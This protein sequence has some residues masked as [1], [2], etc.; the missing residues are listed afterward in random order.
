MRYGRPVN[1]NSR[2]PARHQLIIGC[3][4]SG[5]SQLLGSGLVVP[6]KRDTR[7][8][9]YDDVGVLPG[10][11]Y[12]T[13]LGFLGALRTAKKRNNGFSVFYGGTQTEEDYCWFCDVVWSQLDGDRLTHVVSE[14]V[15]TSIHRSGEAPP[16]VAIMM[17]QGRKYGLIHTATGQYPSWISS[18]FYSQSRIKYVGQQEMSDAKK[19]SLVAGVTEQQIKDLQSNE[20]RCEF[21]R[22]EGRSTG[23]ELVV[24][25]P[26]DPVGIKWMD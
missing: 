15:N 25:K 14:E 18:T 17:V 21:Y 16:E 4:G 12:S 22:N 7:L 9:G 13:R 10:L 1:P 8:I 20:K 5:K 23:G 11:Y 26:R 2:H 19:M 6:I 3:T 24:V